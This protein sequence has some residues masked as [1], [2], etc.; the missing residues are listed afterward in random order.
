MGSMHRRMRLLYHMMKPKP[1]PD[2]TP[3]FRI[4]TGDVVQVLHGKEQG[5]CAATH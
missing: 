5:E 1:E 2:F 3:K 4:V